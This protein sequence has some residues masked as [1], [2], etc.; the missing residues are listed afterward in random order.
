MS[1]LKRIGIPILVVALAALALAACGWASD[2]VECGTSAAGG[3]NARTQNNM[4]TGPITL[5]IPANTTRDGDLDTTTSTKE[6]RSVTGSGAPS[7]GYLITV[8]GG[9]AHACLASYQGST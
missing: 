3:T 4:A 5:N 6:Y 1:K 9:G 7:G 8:S 2:P